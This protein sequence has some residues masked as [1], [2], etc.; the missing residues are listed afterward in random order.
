MNKRGNGTANE[1]YFNNI[2]KTGASYNIPNKS[3]NHN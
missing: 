1:Y 2:Y 3:F